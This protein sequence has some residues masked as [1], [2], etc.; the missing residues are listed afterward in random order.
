MAATRNS[1]SDGQSTPEYLT[2]RKSYT[3]L[4][5]HIKTQP[6]D[7]CDA[8]FEK[9]F[10]PPTVRDFVRSRSVLDDEKA[11]RLVDTVIDR[12]EQDSCVYNSFMSILN[13]DGP[14]ADPIVGQ[15]EEAFKAEQA[16]SISEVHED[17][18]CLASSSSNKEAVKGID[19][20]SRSECLIC[21]GNL[22]EPKLLPCFHSF[23]KSPC[24]IELAAQDPEGKTLT[25]PACQYLVNL[26]NSGVVGLQTDFRRVNPL[27]PKAEN[28]LLCNVC[29]KKSSSTSFCQKCG[30]MCEQCT[31][32]HNEWGAFKSHKIYSID[33]VK[34]DPSMLGCASAIKC[35]AHNLEANI[36]CGTCSELICSDCTNDIHRG[37]TFQFVKHVVQ[38]HRKE[39]VS[40]LD[41]LKKMSEQVKQAIDMFEIRAENVRDQNDAIKAEIENEIEKLINF[42]NKHKLELIDVLN[43]LTQEKLTELSTQ[44]KL[45]EK[46]NAQVCSCLEYA[47]AGLETGTEGEVVRMK[48]PVLKRIEEITAEFNLDAIQPKTEADIKLITDDQIYQACSNFYEVTTDSMPTSRHSYITGDGFAV[49][50]SEKESSVV[51]HLRNRRNRECVNDCGL[52]ADF[53]LSHTKSKLGAAVKCNT[54]QENGR[55]TVNYK[56]INRG[57]HILSVK[58]N[59]KHIQGSPYPIVV[60]PSK[61]SLSKPIRVVCNVKRSDVEQMEK[62][63]RPHRAITNSKG[64]IVVGDFLAQKVIIMTT[65]GKLLHKFGGRGTKSGKFRQPCGIAVDEGDNIYVTDNDNNRIQKFDSNGTFIN[66]V[67]C[68]GSNNLQFHFPVGI[69]FNKTDHNLYICDQNN[70]RIQVI[71]TDLKFVKCFGQKGSRDGQ[72][73]RPKY[74]AFDD[75]NNLYVTDYVNNRVQVFTADGEFLRIIS[76]KSSDQQLEEPY[77]IAIDSANIVYVSE[78]SRNC[79]SMFTSGGDYITSFGETGEAAGQFNRIRGLS[80]G[81]NDSLIVSEAGNSRIQIF[82]DETT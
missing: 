62:L 13:K 63:K 57:R 82:S 50:N 1:T 61:E 46:T 32:T 8:L 21:R 69:C 37:H 19:S 6:G 17:S 14:W 39:L 64:H 49:K 60:T 59:G 45:V 4:V 10:I 53:E 36:F 27:E 55:C 34:S 5:M 54:K 71:T 28:E 30:R 7:I 38:Q 3:K 25:C 47:E 81:E 76:K 65:E 41:Q 9:G 78:L 43:S 80:I 33:E 23:C 56:P 52:T 74:S 24:L 42:L 77:G 29:D 31:N 26:P 22:K 67:G 79:I 40:H 72:L 70:H 16:A 73:E 58:F 66:T 75:S 11:Q 44:K 2:L 68:L 12:V 51:V 15:L 18:S 35:E 20:R 48:A